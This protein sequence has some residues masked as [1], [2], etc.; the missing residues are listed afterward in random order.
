VRRR[1]FLFSLSK[2]LAGFTT[3]IALAG[4]FNTLAQVSGFSLSSTI[5]P[6]NSGLGTAGLNT[7]SNAWASR[8]PDIEAALAQAVARAKENESNTPPGMPTQD[9]VV[10]RTL[11][12]R[13][14][15]IYEQQLSNLAELQTAIG[16]RAEMNQQ[17][18]KWS[19][20]TTSRPYSILLADSLREAVA[21]ERSRIRADEQALSA[22]DGLIT[23]NRESVAGAEEKIRRLNEQ[24]EGVAQS[25][26]LSSQRELEQIRSQVALAALTLLDLERRIRQENLAASRS[27]LDLLQKQLL[28]A[29]ADVKFTEAD[30]EKVLAGIEADRVRLE[31]ELME[32]EKRQGAALAALEAAQRGHNQS[33]GGAPAERALELSSL[34]TA[35]WE[36]AVSAVRVLR[37]QLEAGSI[38]RSLWEARYAAYGSS[39]VQTLRDSERRLKTLSKRAA[40]WNEYFRQKLDTTSNQITLEEARIS[41]ADPDSEL[42]PLM[43]ERLIALRER[44]QWLLS[45]VQTAER[46]QSLLERCSEDLARDIGRLPLGERVQNLFSDARSFLSNLW[47]FELFTAEDTITVGGQKISGRRS[48]TVGKVAGAVLILLVGYW[49]TGLVSLGGKRAAQRWLNVEPNQGELIRRWLRTALVVCLILFSLTSV[50][51]PLTIFAFAGGALAIGIGF[52]TQTILKN[53][54]SGLIILFERPF[55]VGDVLDVGGQKGTLT[56]IGLRASVLQLW[57]GT[58]SLFPN[59]QLLENVLTNW[60]YSNRSVRFALTVG[61]AYGSDTR[62]VVQL[63]EEVV[64][65]HG[66]VEA[67]PKPQVFF[68]DFGASSLS[69]ETR[70]W[71][72]VMKT[73]PAQVSSDLR[74]MIAVAFAE[75]GIVIAFPQQDLHLNTA[76]P[77]LVEMVGKGGLGSG[78]SEV[79]NRPDPSSTLLS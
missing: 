22:L 75:T 40:L 59:S 4:G 25:G 19:G 71:L 2:G 39:Q 27:H 52:G 28:A 76:R 20:F 53:V 44:S 38:E 35:Q 37:L 41:H 6:A 46:L 55:R 43:R 18:Q 64:L 16:H 72:D 68:S 47:G 11:L 78:R 24:L 61:V 26:S 73:N 48:V 56:S 32:A 63:L 62:R 34:R 33:Q 50:K 36:C 45:M 23:E 30:R 10:R 70:F 5:Q 29:N 58:E 42:A 15:R 7:S 8:V 14:V 49:I 54:V 66:L 67:Q 69:F 21:A 17:A 12:Q 3:L 57:D 60:T 74:H 13:L 1:R 51:I 65:R 79:R 9:A 31:R 77:L